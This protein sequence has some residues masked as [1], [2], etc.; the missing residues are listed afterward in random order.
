MIFLCYLK[1]STCKKA[2]VFLDEYKVKYDF[3]DIKLKNP[4]EKELK[5]WNKLSGLPLKRFFNTSGL[6]YKEYQLKDKLET[7]SKDEQL[8][9]LAKDG[10]LVK[11]PMLISDEFVL[12]GFRE[13]EW[14]KALKIK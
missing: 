9:M 14:K 10:M 7:M 11:R 2:Q 12:V 1:C 13:E 6:L 8:K 4:N 5:K 3:R